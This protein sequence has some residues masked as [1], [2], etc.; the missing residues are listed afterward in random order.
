M[1]KYSLGISDFRNFIES[2]SFFIDKTLLIKE[3]IKDKSGVLLFPRP[4]RFGKTLN[5]S[6]IKYFFDLN[7]D[8]RDIEKLFNKFKISEDKEII[9]KM[10]SAPVIYLKL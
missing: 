5:M 2:G 6:M 1:N 10:N 3:I 4:R 8:K 7:E 9:K